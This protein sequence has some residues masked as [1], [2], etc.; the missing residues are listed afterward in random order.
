MPPYEVINDL[1]VIEELCSS[2]SPIYPL[3]MYMSNKETI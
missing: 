1:T 2:F 3:H